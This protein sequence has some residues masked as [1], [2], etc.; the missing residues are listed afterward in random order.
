MAIDT[1]PSTQQQTIVVVCIVSPIVSTLFVAIRLWTRAF[2]VHS[3]GKDDCKLP[4]LCFI[5][6]LR[7]HVIDAA[8][9]TLVRTGRWPPP[10][11]G[12]LLSFEQPVC[13]GFSAIIG[14]GELVAF[15]TSL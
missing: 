4:H 13:I 12:G 9:I 11:R 8:F 10:F 2:V 14:L 15:G 7:S 1:D 5:A 3:L 6:A